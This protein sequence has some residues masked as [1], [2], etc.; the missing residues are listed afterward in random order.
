MLDLTFLIKL[1]IDAG[2]IKLIWEITPNDAPRA[3]VKVE[4]NTC[5]LDDDDIIQNL[6]FKVELLEFEHFSQFYTDNQ[7]PL[8]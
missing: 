3:D 1:V 2:F 6:E 8:V 4:L 7:W 5:E